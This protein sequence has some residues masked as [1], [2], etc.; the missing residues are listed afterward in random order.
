MYSIT[1]QILKDVF[2]LVPSELEQVQIVEYLDKLC[3]QIDEFISTAKK[4]INELEDMK[5][6]V[7][8]DVVTGKIDV[9][10]VE[11]PEY[12]HIDDV[13]DDGDDEENEEELADAEETEA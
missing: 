9:R 8:S 11:I 7:I 13:V 2:L 10:N 1:Q 5:A 4:K 12:E 6:V 3:Y